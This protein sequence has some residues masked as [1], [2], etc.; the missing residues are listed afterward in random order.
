MIIIFP[1][2]KIKTKD[3]SD[4]RRVKRIKR[5]LRRL[6]GPILFHAPSN[7]GNAN[8]ERIR[9]RIFRFPRKEE[10]NEFFTIDGNKKYV[11]LNSTLF[12]KKHYES[13]LYILHGIAHSFC[14]L[15]DEMVEEAFCEF[16]SY[17][18]LERLLEN[19]GRLFSKRIIRNAMFNSPHKYNTFYMAAKKL[20]GKKRGIMLELN[21]KAKNKKISKRRQRRI[22]YRLMKRRKL[23]Q[24]DFSEEIPELEK[25]FRMV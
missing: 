14:Y 21:S 23:G 4:I 3:I 17:S 18:I 22:F 6:K 15:G 19:K 1:Q 2:I 25:G 8:L 12:N 16:V 10:C 20:D 11:C 5:D 24:D 13:L 9:I 7:F